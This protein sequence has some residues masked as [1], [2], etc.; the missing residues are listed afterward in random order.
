MK[1]RAELRSWDDDEGGMQVRPVKPTLNY[2]LHV[3]KL[4][5]LR[6]LFS[7]HHSTSTSSLMAW[8]RILK[9]AGSV[10]FHSYLHL[11][12][13]SVFGNKAKLISNQCVLNVEWFIYVTILP[14]SPASP[15]DTSALQHLQHRHNNHRKWKNSMK[16]KM[17]Q[18]GKTINMLI[19]VCDANA[20]WMCI[21]YCCTIS[22]WKTRWNC[23]EDKMGW[24]DAMRIKVKLILQVFVWL[25]FGSSAKR[26]LNLNSG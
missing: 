9:L 23:W 22:V 7:I 11:Y 20:R 3:I 26:I 21:F 16:M 15:N 10:A 18:K 5:L 14:H 24:F 12:S 2:Y 4:V 1:L 17:R 25:D 6:A 13:R 19:L 8:N